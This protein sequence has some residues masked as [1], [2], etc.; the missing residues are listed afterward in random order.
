MKGRE[1]H[2]LLNE[3]AQGRRRRRADTRWLWEKAY[4]TDSQAYSITSE[5][6]T[7]ISSIHLISNPYGCTI[8][9]FPS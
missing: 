1:G 2:G 5:L 3:R 8:T 6:I 9:T 7:L 4:L